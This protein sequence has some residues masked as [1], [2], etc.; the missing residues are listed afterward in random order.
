MTGPMQRISRRRGGS[1]KERKGAA[2]PTARATKL[3]ATASATAPS[4]PSF[5]ERGGLRRRL[6][7]LRRARELAFR[8]LG[9]LVFD[10]HRFQR[11]R[12]DLVEAKLSALAAVDEE[13]RGLEKVLEDERPLHELREAGVSSC[14]RCGALHSSADRFCPSC[15]VS[16]RSADATQQRTGTLPAQPPS[17]T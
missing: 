14:P 12:P 13:L 17:R 2:E 1:E 8:D 15:G 7:Y 9:G 3:T 10:L 4:S 5:R 16:L 11:D 6:R